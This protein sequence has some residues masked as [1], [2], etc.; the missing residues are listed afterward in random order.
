MEGKGESKGEEKK[1]SE[2]GEEKK[3]VEKGGEEG[4]GEERRGKETS[5]RERLVLDDVRTLIIDVTPF[6]V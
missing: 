6:S 4:G 3:G 2:G 5:R 1:V